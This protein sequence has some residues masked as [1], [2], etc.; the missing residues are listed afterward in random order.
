MEV[1]VEMKE[2]PLSISQENLLIKEEPVES[3]EEDKLVINEPVK[4]ELLE[5][6]EDDIP[7]V[8]NEELQVQQDEDEEEEEND[9]MPLVS[10]QSC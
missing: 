9:D 5:D 2:E 6:E 3:E 8:S 4:E 10:V 1:K 7:L